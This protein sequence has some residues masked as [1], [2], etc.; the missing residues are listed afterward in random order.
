MMFL[1]NSPTWRRGDPID[2]QHLVHS[3]ACASL[4]LTTDALAY[5]PSVLF[6]VF[7]ENTGFGIVFCFSI[8]LLFFDMKVT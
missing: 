8:F 7:L 3:T 6:P 2:I 1:Q 4:A 5:S